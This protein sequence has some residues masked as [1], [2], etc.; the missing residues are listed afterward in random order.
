MS[1]LLDARRK[2]TGGLDDKWSSAGPDNPNGSLWDGESPQPVCMFSDTGIII[3][4]DNSHF[5]TCFS[6]FCNR[7]RD[8]I[9]EF[10]KEHRRDQTINSN[11]F[12]LHYLLACISNCIILK[13]DDVQVSFYSMSVFVWGLFKNVCVSHSFVSVRGAY[14]Q[15]I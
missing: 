14:K 3:L 8:A 12:Y 2:C 13:W 1:G 7:F 6:L 10:G 5:C 9:I 11:K 15:Y 4:I